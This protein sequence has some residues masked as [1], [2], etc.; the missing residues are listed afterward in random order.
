MEVVFSL[1]MPIN[2][3]Y[4]LIYN[5]DVYG[6]RVFSQIAQEKFLELDILMQGCFPLS[7]YV[8]AAQERFVNTLLLNGCMGLISRLAWMG[9]SNEPFVN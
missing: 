9:K 8:L 6:G 4:V 2:V 3:F 7:H 5:L 1:F